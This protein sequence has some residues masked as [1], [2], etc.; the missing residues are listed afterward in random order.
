MIVKWLARHL[1]KQ[2]KFSGIQA[3]TEMLA[4]L[5]EETRQKILENVAKE[6]PSLSQNIRD[7][8]FVFEDLVSLDPKDLQRLVRALPLKTWAMAL[9]KSSDDLRAAVKAQMTVRMAQAL[10]E[11]M[12]LMGPQRISDVEKAQRELVNEALKL[13]GGKNF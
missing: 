5:D 10:Q 3:V 6:D 7:R 13:K 1:L 8:L 4:H 2:G 9:R 12:D 11:E